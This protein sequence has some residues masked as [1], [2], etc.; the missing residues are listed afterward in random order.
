MNGEVVERL[1]VLEFISELEGGLESGNISKNNVGKLV[2]SIKEVTVGSIT[3][4][5]K[6]F[7]DARELKEIVDP[8]KIM[9]LDQDNSNVAPHE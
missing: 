2:L 8:L 4:S 5:L 3:S 6:L 1:E 9:R 7:T